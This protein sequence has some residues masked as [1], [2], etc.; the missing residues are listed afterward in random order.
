MLSPITH[1][2]LK[3]IQETDEAILCMTGCMAASALCCSQHCSA[4]KLDK[5][6]VVSKAYTSS[7]WASTSTSPSRHAVSHAAAATHEIAIATT[8]KLA[9]KPCGDW[10]YLSQLEFSVTHAKGVI[11]DCSHCDVHHVCWWS[12]NRRGC[13][14]A[15]TCRGSTSFNRLQCVCVM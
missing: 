11:R 6:G 10:N 4:T 1:A 3:V 9:V 15:Q 14:M 2:A 12:T 8:R 7:R 13:A 5:P